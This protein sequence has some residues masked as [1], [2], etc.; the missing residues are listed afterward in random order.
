MEKLSKNKL[1]LLLSF[2]KKKARDEQNLFLAEG[3]KLVRDLLPYF[4]C[5]TIVGTVDFFEKEEIRLESDCYIATKEE[6]ERLSLTRSPQA[7][8]ALFERKEHNLN[9]SELKEKLSLALDGVQDPGNLG[10]IIR[11]A[12]WFGIENIICS[13]NCVDLYNPKV[14]Q[15]TMGAIARVKI[16]YTD[17]VKL[18]DSVGDL[19]IYGTFLEGDIIYETPLSSNGIIVMGNEGNG[20]SE[21]VKQRITQKLFIPNYPSNRKTSESLNVAVATSIVC[22]EFRRR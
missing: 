2:T 6:L 8:W 1:R 3:N 13:S 20:I 7:V 12:D 4:H 15:A 18:M 16:H 14:V 17:L 21:E 9:L 10:T 22:S 5:K 19:P 11:I